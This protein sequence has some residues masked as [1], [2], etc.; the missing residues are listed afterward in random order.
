MSFYSITLPLS[1]VFK[2][3]STPSDSKTSNPIL[4][5]LMTLQSISLK[6]KSKQSEEK[7][8]VIPPACP[9]TFVAI[10]L[11]PLVAIYVN[12][13]YS[14]LGLTS[15]FVYYIVLPPP[16]QI[17][18][19]SYS[20]LTAILS[21]STLYWIVPISMPI[22]CIFSIFFF[23][24]QF[25]KI[26]YLFIHERHTERGKNTSRRRSRLPVGSPMWDWIPGPGITP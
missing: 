11:P 9:P 16:T 24:F 17:H 8:Q 14:Y 5:L 19:P 6:K 25:F 7:S 12:F 2:A 15:S 26:F 13:P 3:F 4:S 20:F 10:Y 23:L 18:G 21:V 22:C 1:Q